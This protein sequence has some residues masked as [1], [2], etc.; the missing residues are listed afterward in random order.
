MCV[1]VFST[2]FCWNIF[3]VRRIMPHTV[4][5][6]HNLYVRYPL[7]LS[8]FNETWIFSTGFWQNFKYQ[9]SWKSIKWKSNCS[10][11]TERRTDNVV[12]SLLSQFW[13]RTQNNR[14]WQTL[15]DRHVQPTECKARSNVTSGIACY[16]TVLL[17]TTVWGG[18]VAWTGKHQ[19]V[20]E[21][22]LKQYREICLQ[23]L[24]RGRHNWRS[25][26]HLKRC[27][28]R[29]PALWALWADISR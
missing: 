21:V 17:V 18:S 3:I 24:D 23:D 25:S 9:I 10:M 14:C 26:R 4:T 22:Q 13:E 7:Y 11:R 5:N 12:Y 1:L 19:D 28:L 8:D 15:T 16:L 6:V 2:A 20:K 27:W 29:Y